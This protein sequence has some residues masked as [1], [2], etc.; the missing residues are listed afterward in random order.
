VSSRR[1]GDPRDQ[2][3]RLCRQDELA[4]SAASM[5]VPL[6]AKIAGV[7][8]LWSPVAL[9]PWPEEHRNLTTPHSGGLQP[10]HFSYPMV[11]VPRWLAGDEDLR[12]LVRLFWFCCSRARPPEPI[13]YKLLVCLCRTAW[14]DAGHPGP[15][16]QQEGE[17]DAAASGHAL[18]AAPGLQPSGVVVWRA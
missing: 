3:A 11:Q 7:L 17:R 15:G 5:A 16:V 13:P 2:R 18:T 6:C 9:A 14:K 4:I 8:S 1:G 10:S 12:W